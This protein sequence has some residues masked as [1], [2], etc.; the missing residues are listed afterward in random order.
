MRWQSKAGLPSKV[1]LL[2][3]AKF[4]PKNNKQQNQAQNKKY[5]MKYKKPRQKYLKQRQSER[6][7]F[8]VPA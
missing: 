1:M 8:F 6:L 2:K 4:H 3:Q 7:R 5:N